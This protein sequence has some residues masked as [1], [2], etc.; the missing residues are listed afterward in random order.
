VAQ[1]PAAIIP[2]LAMLGLE[3]KQGLSWFKQ[4]VAWKKGD[5]NWKTHKNKTEAKY[6]K[7]FHG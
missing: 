6:K 2:L 7:E 5:L 1:Q 3:R 4:E